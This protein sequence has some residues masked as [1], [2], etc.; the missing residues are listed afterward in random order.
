MK[1]REFIK[2][3]GGKVFSVS[4]A[5]SLLNSAITQAKIKDYDTYCFKLGQYACTIFKD[6]MFKYQGKDYFINATEGEVNEELHRYHQKTDHI[7]SP[8][9]AFLL[10]HEKEKILIDTGIGYAKE[11]LNFRGHTYQ[12]Q[13]SLMEILEKEGV[14]KNEITHVILTHFHPDHIGGIYNESGQLNFPNAK[15]IVH[16]DEWNYWHSS[17]AANQPPLFGYFI[18]KHVSGL[19]NQQL[20]LIKGKEK[21]ILPG[22]V[23]IQTPGHTPGQVALSIISGKDKLLYISDA[24]LHPL[25]IEHL[26][27]QTNY[28][29]DHEVAKASRKKLLE[30]AYSEDMNVQ[31]FHFDFPGLG[32]AEKSGKHWKWRYSK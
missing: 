24:F 32:K 18:E 22:I 17:K 29:Q 9:I 3:K 31:A 13:G 12:F 20:E 19:K 30:L 10:E 4:F 1:R 26:K 8:F 28:D 7:P 11:P 21:E 25:H 15:F 14:N 27:W 16:E 5:P 6:L 2:I 23:A